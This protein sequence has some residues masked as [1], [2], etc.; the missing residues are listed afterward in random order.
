MEQ[1]YLRGHPCTH[2]GGY[3]ACPR[4]KIVAGCDTNEDRLK[5]FGREWGAR[6]YLDYRQML[7]KED[8]DIVS[9]CSWTDT[10]KEMTIAAASAGVKGVICEKPMAANLMDADAMIESCKA[11]K[12]R[13]II[14]HERR[15]DPDYR[16]VKELIDEGAIGEIRTIVG[17]ALTGA[18][19]PRDWHADYHQVGGGPMLHDGTHL[20]DMIRF[21]GGEADWVFG[22]IERRT[23][24]IYVEDIAQAFIHLKSGIHASIEGGGIRNYFN[25][26][27]DI[28]GS[29]GRILIGNG[30]SGMWVANKSPH[31]LGFME[32]EKRPFPTSEKGGNPWILQV[33]DMI[34]C[35]E[36][37][38]ESISSGYDGRQA[39]ELVMA[40]YESA[41]LGGVKVSFPLN[42]QESPL[43]SMLREGK[44]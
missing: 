9:I 32:L 8:L 21:F 15:W 43:D 11:H 31:Y 18:P 36:N 17:N 23:E 35:I 37:N 29:K 39:L 33:E 28:Q 25:F 44:L 41:R 4:T 12:T 14:N 19:A 1:D 3:N 22:H 34:S 40:I 42:I 30:V 5:L 6:L 10:H 27:L 13:L 38:H 2:A 24:G 16:K 26:E 20:V 7:D